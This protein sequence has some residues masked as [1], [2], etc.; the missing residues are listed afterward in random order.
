MIAAASLGRPAS[1]A[2]ALRVRTAKAYF[3]PNETMLKLADD[4]LGG[5]S[6]LVDLVRGLLPPDR[7]EDWQPTV[8]P[9]G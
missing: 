4:L 7:E 6:G 8:I 5:A 1:A 9:L 2:L 3:R